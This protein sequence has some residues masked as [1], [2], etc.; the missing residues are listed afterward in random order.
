M[1]R[2]I[3]LTIVL[4][5]SFNSTYALPL[6]G[7]IFFTQSIISIS[8]VFFWLL[9]FIIFFFKNNIFL[10]N[11]FS[12]ILLFIM[13]SYYFYNLGY[14]YSKFEFLLLFIFFGLIYFFRKKIILLFIN[15]IIIFI[16]IWLIINYNY[17]IHNYNSIINSINNSSNIKLLD[18]YS[19]V[20]IK[21]SFNL[22]DVDFSNWSNIIRV[23]FYLKWEKQD[24]KVFEY[25]N[26]YFTRRNNND[27]YELV[28]AINKLLNK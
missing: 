25:R 23:L 16:F 26:L 5:A 14:F 2:N 27:W 28:G 18:E 9:L 21:K 3:F 22:M 10:I 11:I 19:I 8:I 15:F 1:Y 6:I 4:L 12:T 17:T 24:D 20:D 13:Y 7:T